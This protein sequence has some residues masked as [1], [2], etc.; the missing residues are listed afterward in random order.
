LGWENFS[1]EVKNVGGVDYKRDARDW[2]I[3]S[4]SKYGGS[5]PASPNNATIDRT[6][7]SAGFGATMQKNKDIVNGVEVFTESYSVGW[8][9]IG[10]QVNFD[11]KQNVTDVRFGI[12]SGVSIAIF[13][14]VEISIQMGGIYVFK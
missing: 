12:D 3:S 1:F 5:R 13:G 8:E 6:S 7:V 4:S 2:R 11:A 14:G 10:L 9:A